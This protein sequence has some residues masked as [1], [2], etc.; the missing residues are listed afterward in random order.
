MKTIIIV[1]LLRCLTFADS[2]IPAYPKGEIGEMVKLGED[3]IKNTSTHPLTKDLVHNKLN[4]V[5]CHLSGPDMHPGNT[6]TMG[7][8]S[9]IAA[10]FPFY[11]TREGVVITLQD[12]VDNCFMRSMDGT[13]PIIDSKAS[14]AMAAYITWL[15]TGSVIDINPAT[16]KAPNFSADV[17]K[18]AK[19]QKKASHENFKNGGKVFETMCATCHGMDGKGVATFPPL[20]GKDSSGKYLSYNTGA[21]MS[22]LDKSAAWIQQN[23][24]LGAG[25]SLSNQ[26][27]A[28]V[29]IYINAQDRAPFDLS[30]KLDDIKDQGYYNSKRLKEVDNL[31]SN[32]KKMGLDLKTIRGK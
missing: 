31:E 29:A 6:Q 17:K 30:K 21:G 27:A 18:F 22:K 10:K 11:N 8:F 1:A 7:T 28:D 23:M 3:I 19:I 13:R 14:I 32:F 5:S 9:G 16:S 20:W 25:G 26:E 24:P 12:R 2:N 15:S 4:C